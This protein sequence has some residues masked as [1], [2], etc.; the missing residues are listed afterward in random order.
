MVHF[1][2]MARS[3]LLIQLDQRQQE[4]SSVTFSG[5]AWSFPVVHHLTGI[6]RPLTNVSNSPENG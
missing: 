5:A 6:L 2:S 4:T 1:N 3:Y